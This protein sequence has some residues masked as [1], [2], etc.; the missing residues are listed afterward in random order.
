MNTKTKIQMIMDKAN[1]EAGDLL[2]A[3]IL[4]RLKLIKAANKHIN[5]ISLVSGMGTW[6]YKI[7]G[8]FSDSYLFNPLNDYLEYMAGEYDLYVSDIELKD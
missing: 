1:K 4:A 2:H 6:V 7:N 3:E 5:T 8:K